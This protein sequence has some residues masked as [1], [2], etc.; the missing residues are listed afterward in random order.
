IGN[1]QAHP[2]IPRQPVPAT[3]PSQ[4]GHARLEIEAP[5]V[6]CRAVSRLAW[7]PGPWPDNAHLASQHVP[8][9]R[10][11]VQRPVAQQPADPGD[12]SVVLDNRETIADTLCADDHRA[13]FKA[14]KVFPSPADAILNKKN[15]SAVIELDP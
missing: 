10:N 2:F 13:E 4:A 6:L 7:H 14:A 3:D 5:A 8:K 11:L 1:I 9:L 12:T 15:R